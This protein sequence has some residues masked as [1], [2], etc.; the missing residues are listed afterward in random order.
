MRVLSLG[1]DAIGHNAMK[2]H[3]WLVFWLVLLSGTAVAIGVPLAHDQ[4]LGARPHH[5]ALHSMLFMVTFS[6]AAAVALIVSA[7]RDGHVSGRG[8]GA[9]KERK[10]RR[11]R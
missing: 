7:R 1:V 11:K 10:T 8:S 2:D 5:P 6:V 3:N 9:N 4:H